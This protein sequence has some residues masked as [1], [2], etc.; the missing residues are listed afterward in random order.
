MVCVGLQQFAEFAAFFSVPAS[1][2]KFRPLATNQKAGGS[3]PSGRA[4]PNILSSSVLIMLT[5]GG[6]GPVVQGASLHQKGNGREV[7][8]GCAG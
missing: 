1:S 2:R 8:S 3:N 7:E 6:I 4:N 5:R